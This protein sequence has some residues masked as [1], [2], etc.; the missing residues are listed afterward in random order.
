MDM[1]GNRE[2]S[3]EPESCTIELSTGTLIRET[4]RR[5]AE[6]A[7]QVRDHGA[8]PASE[9]YE[10]LRSAI[11]GHDQES[12]AGNEGT[13]WLHKVWSG[14]YHVVEE[15][16]ERR[17]EPSRRELVW[18][19]P[20][21]VIQKRLVD[22]L[23][24]GLV[25]EA[26]RGGPQITLMEREIAAEQGESAE[27]GDTPAEPDF[28][29]TTAGGQIGGWRFDY[30]R[31]GDEWLVCIDNRPEIDSHDMTNGVVHPQLQRATVPL[32]VLDSVVRLGR[33]Q[34]T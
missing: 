30:V 28:K 3:P 1:P 14:A 16:T 20:P 33:N 13:L 32:D 34:P 27:V 22:M 23:R 11:K 15:Q 12:I 7:Q 19:L 18:L 26:H 29:P 10:F 8:D 4:G 21:A 24:K 25:R 31:E 17:L 6:G 5:L 9:Q 2:G